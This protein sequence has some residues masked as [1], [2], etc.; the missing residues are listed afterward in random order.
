[1][2]RCTS[3]NACPISVRNES[4]KTAQRTDDVVRLP[5]G[6]ERL[7][8][9]IVLNDENPNQKESVDHGERYREPNGHIT[10]EVHRYP[11]REKGQERIENL[12]GR[13]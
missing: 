3:K 12:D 6:G 8:A 9:A 10:P 11:D 2:G 7:V 13:F 1:M 5:G 4:Q